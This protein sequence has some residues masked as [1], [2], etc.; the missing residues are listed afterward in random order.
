MRSASVLIGRSAPLSAR[1]DSSGIERD[2]EQ[3]AELPRFFEISDMPFVDQIK[4]A[5]GED[6]ALAFFAG[7]G[8]RS[9]EGRGTFH[10]R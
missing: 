1:T 10:F 5:V 4:A 8:E 6:R 7:R 2:D 9:R 3:I